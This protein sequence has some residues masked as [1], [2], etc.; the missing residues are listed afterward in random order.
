MA[1]GEQDS[2]QVFQFLKINANHT[3]IN[4]D[5]IVQEYGTSKV[6]T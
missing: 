1:V 3:H 2:F 6:P 4:C 5:E